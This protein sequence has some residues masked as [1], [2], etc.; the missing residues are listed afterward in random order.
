MAPPFPPVAEQMDAIL[1][2]ALEAVP[3]EELERKLHR[4][5][6]SGQPL[7]V[8]QGF[9]P[10]RPD[11][12]LGHAVS[13]R[14]LRTFQELGHQVVFVVGDYTAR[15]G[16]PTGRTELRPPLTEDE[17]REN[18]R[19]YAEQ[20]FRILDASRT[21]VEYNSTWLAPLRLEDLL[22]LTAQ[23]TV[24]RMM[25]RED[26]QTRYAEGKPISI[27]EFLYPLMTA[28]DSVA[29]KADVELGGS[30]QK[31]NLLVHRTIQE[32]YGQE[33]QVCL[34]MPLLRGTDGA[35]KMSKSYDNYVGLAQAPEEQY[36]RTMSIPDT[37]LEEWWRLA[38]GAEG[39]ALAH[40]VDLARLDPYRAKRE[41]ASRVVAQYHGHDAAA[42]AA[43]HFD[44]VFR[45]HDVPEE[46]PEHALRADD[47]AVAAGEGAAGLPRVLVRVGLASS[48]S[49]AMRLIDQGAVAVDGARENARDAVL[50]APGTYLL[51]KGKRHFARV[52]LS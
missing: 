27:V 24:A 35:H 15:V 25:E 43:A 36:G 2:D 28:Y 4:S 39:D 45:Q 1:R 10:T 5:A 46:V 11:L 21:R 50:R 34:L 14:K 22:R 8:K 7:I 33:P 17:V 49:E 12:H 47:P 20:V 6:R 30:D 23:H 52:R 37:L 51:R 3:Q 41:L 18:A 38:S 19:T 42:S 40:G 29:L 13:L 48:N 32:R 44:R 16:D 26:F 9:D 31:F